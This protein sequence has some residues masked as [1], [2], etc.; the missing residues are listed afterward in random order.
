MV[1]I[2]DNIRQLYNFSAPCPE[3]EAYIEF[4][5]ESSFE[6]TA[7]H[8]NNSSF[9][10]KMFPS[11]TPT[12]WINLGASYRLITAKNN[13]HIGAADD[14]LVLRDSVTERQ[15]LPAD[16]IFT[17]KFFPG[18]LEA[19]LGINQAQFIN[20]VVAL[21]DILPAMLLH[22]VKT[23]ASFEERMTLL[24]HFF[25]LQLS[26]QQKK[27]H[28]IHLVKNSIDLYASN[29]MQYNTSEI[30][31]RLFVSSK[32]INR[33]FHNVVG[34]SP[35]KYFSILR[36]RAALTAY[37]AARETFSPCHHGYHDMSH[38]Y[39][40]VISFTGRRLAVQQ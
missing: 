23:A 21:K 19:I 22:H 31:E 34:L 16:Y 33:Y 7:L 20:T 39:K 25:L 35:K 10:V 1:E 29:R 5:S 12:M 6:E 30:A 38:F 11:W 9:T 18:G 14:V 17:V 13:Y 32:T 40:E 8:A 3:L 15:N 24:Q 27:D 4:I 26:R 37:V 36:A 28:Y 2:F